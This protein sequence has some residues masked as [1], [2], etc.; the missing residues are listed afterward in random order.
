MLESTINAAQPRK[1][2]IGGMVQRKTPLQFSRNEY[3]EMT[4]VQATSMEWLVAGRESVITGIVDELRPAA[5]GAANPQMGMGILLT[6]PF[7]IGKSHLAVQAAKALQPEALVV[8]LYASAQISSVPYGALAALLS[9]SDP[10]NTSHPV[11]VLTDTMRRLKSMS[12]GKSVCILVDNAN[13]LDEHSAVVLAQLARSGHIR[14]LLT[15]GSSDPLPR[16]LSNLVKDGFVRQ[17]TVEP[18]SFREA[19]KSLET[20][21][22]GSMSRLAGRKLW[23]TSGG[24][25]LFLGALSDEMAKSR[26]LVC[27]GGTWCL[28]ESVAKN[29]RTP[30][31]LFINQLRKLSPPERRTLEIVALS[32]SISIDALLAIVDDTDVDALEELGL[33]TIDAGNSVKASSPLLALVVRGRVPAGRSNSLWESVHSRS[34]MAHSSVEP[35]GVGM[36][37]WTLEC[38]R[39]LSNVEAVAAARTAND[40]MRPRLALSFLATIDAQPARISAAAEAVRAYMILGNCNSA[41]EVL[42]TFH[43]ARHEEPTLTEWVRL[44]LAET[45]VLLASEVTWAEADANLMKVRAE[46]YPDS[47][48]FMIEPNEPN[49]GALRRDLALASAKSAC[50]TGNFSEA[51]ADLTRSQEFAGKGQRGDGSEA[52]LGSHLKLLTATSGHAPEA[53]GFTDKILASFDGLP[54]SSAA[55]AREL[56]FYTNLATGRLDSA[57]ELA[58]GFHDQ[59]PENSG[60]HS[61]SFTDLAVPLLTVARGHGGQGL[62]L[63]LPEIV[64]LRLRDQDGALGLA[65]S[66]AAYAS[67]L[68]GDNEAAA[69]YLAELAEYRGGAPWLMGRVGRYFGLAA[70]AK[71]GDQAGSIAQLIQMADADMEAGRDSWEVASLGWALRLGAAGI[72]ERLLVAAC[73]CDAGCSSFYRVFAE[74]RMT[75]DVGVLALAAELAAEDGN[76]AAV[77]D[78]VEAALVLGS[79]DQRQH[80]HLVGLMDSSRRNMDINTKRAGDGQP[81]TSRQLEIAAMAAAG[82]SNKDIAAGLH[83]SIRTAEG[84]LYQIFGKLRISERSEL[85]FALEQA[86]ADW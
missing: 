51:I 37:Q 80:R 26:A 53:A 69:R 30:S 7:G 43:S 12:N 34:A 55:Q 81:L 32:R 60:V 64:Q 38:G 63:L 76:D 5:G 56:L 4:V 45:S 86:K 2:S 77:V 16:E 78:A 36:A 25:P 62:S 52:L 18:F 44:L 72:T 50:W 41:T 11:Q 68:S 83:V 9:E 54:P 17:L 8:R 85:Q 15:C 47:R 74:G 82:A 73:R 70:R 67:V 49:V 21:L 61:S 20:W 28:D 24:N 23:E 27:L 13:D 10:G 75:G 84:H 65:L 59:P 1:R 19:V 6:G 79:V 71:M 40:E 3:G 66:A 39:G 31:E 14:L 46:L 48:D 22:G 57:E 42:K 58:R 35:D 29:E 33:V